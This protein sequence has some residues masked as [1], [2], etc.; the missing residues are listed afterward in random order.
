MEADNVSDAFWHRGYV[1][2]FPY[3]FDAS[4]PEKV[5]EYCDQLTRFRQL[6]FK[7]PLHPGLSLDITIASR[8]ATSTNPNLFRLLPPFALQGGQYQ[9]VLKNAIRCEPDRLSQVWVADVRKHNDE[10]SWG[11]VVL[12]LFQASLLPFPQ[13][14]WQD[15]FGEYSC[16][17][18]LAC[19]EELVYNALQDIQGCTVPYFYGKHALTL[20]NG[21]PTRVNLLEYIE[22]QTLAE[23]H[24]TYPA[25]RTTPLEPKQYRELLKKLKHLYVPAMQGIHEINDRRVVLRDLKPE[26]IMITPSASNQVVFIDFGHAFLNAPEEF[27]KSYPNP[28]RMA[29]CVIK[30]C[31]QHD[32]DVKKWAKKCL[33]PDLQ[34]PIPVPL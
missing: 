19:V 8:K 10:S 12:K 32:N 5:Q 28:L 21:E 30:C 9:L 7:N 13:P 15:P 3:E 31:R 24:D 11:C 29:S 27:V 1:P 17:R 16:P 18:Q 25:H 20:P 6:A 23:L 2:L 14:T 33:S 34:P 4:D 22:G 26:N